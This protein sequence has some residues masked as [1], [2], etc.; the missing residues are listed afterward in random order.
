MY[1]PSR[2]VAF[3]REGL[4]SKNNRTRVVVAEEIAAAVE[5]EGPRIYAVGKGATATGGGAG[6]D[7]LL[8]QVAR[9][10]SGG[11]LQGFGGGG[12]G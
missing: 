11:A 3:M 2:V 8:P 5:R 9:L 12:L 1:P 10:V 4:E 7:Q 6:G